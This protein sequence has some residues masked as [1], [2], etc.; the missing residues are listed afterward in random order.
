MN[1]KIYAFHAGR[2]SVDEANTNVFIYAPLPNSN[3]AVA[4]TNTILSFMPGGSYPSALLHVGTEVPTT[5]EVKLFVSR[6][7]G[8]NW[9][10]AVCTVSETWASS[11]RLVTG[12]VSLTNQPACSNTVVKIEITDDMAL[13]VLG[14][15][16]PCSPEE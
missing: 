5:N 3:I 9:N 7:Y 14:L 2:P 12:S 10:E 8:T 13:T 1:G 11:N 4:A 16:A 15:A 6:D